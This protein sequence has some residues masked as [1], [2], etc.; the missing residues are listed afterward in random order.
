VAEPVESEIKLR[1]RDLEATRE[2]LVRLG[3]TL[4]RPRHFEDNVFLEDE[5]GTL[6]A[7]DSALRL[8]RTPMGGS[9][10]FKGPS[11]ATGGVK[12]RIEIEVFVADPE[13]LEAILRH[14]GYDRSFRYQKHRESYRFEGVEIEVDETPIGTF[15][16]IEGEA[17]AIHRTATALGFRPEDYVSDTYPDLFLAGGGRGDMVF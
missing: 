4:I 11:E 3:A 13:S 9:L 12:R 17:D 2:A 1:I 7:S 5:R 15:L 14:I 6:G 8:R 10:T 16:E